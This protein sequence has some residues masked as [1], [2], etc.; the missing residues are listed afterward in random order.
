MSFCLNV[1]C[2]KPDQNFQRLNF[3]QFCGEKLLLNE[4]YRAL[5]LLGQGGFGKTFLAVDEKNTSQPPCVIKQFFLPGQS[6]E[7]TQK[8]TELFQREA[9]RLEKCGKHSQIPEFYA[10]LEQKGQLYIV[11]EF[12]EGETLAQELKKKGTFSEEEIYTL[13]KD[14]LP[15]LVFIHEKNIIHRDIKPENIIRRQSDHRL[16]LIDFGAAKEVTY[17]VFK[18]IGT[19]IGTPGYVSPEQDLGKPVFASDI[20]SLGVTCLHL[21]TQSE[22]TELYDPNNNAFVWQNKL[23]QPLSQDLINILEKMTRLPVKE[24]FGSASEVLQ[25]LDDLEKKH[26]ATKQTLIN[27]NLLATRKKSFLLKGIA[28]CCIVTAGVLGLSYLFQHSHSTSPP[29]PDPPLTR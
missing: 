1:T 15:V 17:T 26:L 20:F 24:R 13:L 7:I 5:S 28:G 2:T 9:I 22:P 3:C 16:V 19:R 8:A 4:R 21:L 27:S 14:L 23:K 25:V 12:I 29:K 6:P 18:K 10:H 11:Q